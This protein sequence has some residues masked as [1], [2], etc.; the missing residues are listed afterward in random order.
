[1]LPLTAPD[2]WKQ[3]ET[4]YGAPEEVPALIEE[5]NGVSGPLA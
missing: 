5:F 3:L 4:P 1:M 2:I